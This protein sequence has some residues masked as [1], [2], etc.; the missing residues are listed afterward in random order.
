MPFHLRELAPTI[1]TSCIRDK[2]SDG[3]EFCTLFQYL[4]KD[5]QKLVRNLDPDDI[6]F[7]IA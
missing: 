5:K 6:N 2:E 4:V 3:M 1:R 7:P